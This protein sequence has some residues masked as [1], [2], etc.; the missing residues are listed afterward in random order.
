MVKYIIKRV[1]YSILILLLV[2]VLLYMIMR[3]LPTDYIDKSF[4][5]QLNSGVINKDR[6]QEIKALY[7]L[8]DNS[9]AGIMKGYW[10]WFT[11]ALS[12]DLGE[13]F[14]HG[15][16]V[17]QVISDHMWISF[18]IAMAAFI[19]QFLIAIPL[20]IKAATNQYGAVDYTTSVL[21][22]IG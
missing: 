4:E 3:M 17:G 21:A 16:P 14:K 22:M 8:D 12:G 19:F 18:G 10:S 1:L 13:S 2:S 20:G 5:S 6:I 15:A 11:G 9:F 7:G